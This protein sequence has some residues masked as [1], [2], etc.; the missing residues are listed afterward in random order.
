VT[1]HLVVVEDFLGRVVD[2]GNGAKGLAAKED[3]GA[4]ERLPGVADDRVGLEGVQRGGGRRADEGAQAAPRRVHAVEATPAVSAGVRDVAERVVVEGALA[5]DVDPRLTEQPREL[6]VI[7]L[8]QRG[9][10]RRPPHPA[11]NRQLHGVRGLLPSPPRPLGQTKPAPGS[12]SEPPPRSGP[13][14]GEREIWA[15]ARQGRKGA[16][17][18]KTRPRESLCE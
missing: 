6:K 7:R 8:R 10:R 16:G 18:S 2:G 1:A 4:A 11:A 15:L 14:A 5:L 12:A 17:A 9:V 13:S 3:E